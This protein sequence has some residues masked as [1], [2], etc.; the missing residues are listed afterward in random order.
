[1]RSTPLA[2]C[3]VPREWEKHKREKGGEGERRR[4]HLGGNVCPG[5]SCN[6]C[7][8]AAGPGGA[9]LVREGS[10]SGPG[11]PWNHAQPSDSPVRRVAPCTILEN[12]SHTEDYAPQSNEQTNKNM[13]GH[14]A[15]THLPSHPTTLLHTRLCVS[16]FLPRNERK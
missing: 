11:A 6:C 14:H 13:H 12:N 16:P 4:D 8:A 7:T 9:R 3:K 15:T 10:M 1:M 2:L 5:D